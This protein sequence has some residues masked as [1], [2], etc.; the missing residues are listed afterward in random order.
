ML[1]VSSI[2]QERS[3][4]LDTQVAELL[5]PRHLRR[6]LSAEQ[7]QCLT[8]TVPF[9]GKVSPAEGRALLHNPQIEAF[10]G[11]TL[12]GDPDPSLYQQLVVSLNSSENNSGAAH[13]CVKSEIYSPE[14][15]SQYAR[16]EI[17]A[18]SMLEYQAGIDPLL[19]ALKNRVAFM[20]ELS[21]VKNCRVSIRNIFVP[22]DL[23]WHVDEVDGDR[24]RPARMIWTPGRQFG[25]WISPRHNIDIDAFY[26]SKT[27]QQE[28]CDAVDSICRARESRDWRAATKQIASG[29]LD[30]LLDLDQ[31]SFIRNPN[32]R[33]RTSPQAFSV[34]RAENRLASKR[35]WQGTMHK[36]SVENEALAGLQFV[37]ST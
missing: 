35:G 5:V 8:Q 26:G 3:P 31:P 30:F 20:L 33:I 34:H 28:Q 27:F 16:A 7:R 21:Q 11:L 22:G 2:A 6:E 10:Q 37:I 17:A 25:T 13:L 12:E 36:A 18:V 9:F 15:A 32:L 29:M 1:K 24:P 19:V 23:F 4:S 14:Q